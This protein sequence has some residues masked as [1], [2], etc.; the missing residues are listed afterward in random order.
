MTSSPRS[1]S[2][3]LPKPWQ[4]QQR[5]S[6]EP[7]HLEGM[8][9]H[10]LPQ[11]PVITTR[12]LNTSETQSTLL[13]DEHQKVLE[14]LEALEGLGGLATLT[15]LEDLTPW[16]EYPLLISSPASQPASQRL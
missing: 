4:Q 5:P 6:H 3:S 10:L 1:T 7:L 12:T 9:M 16:E 2:Q 14:D 15:D 11:T 8:T 13:L